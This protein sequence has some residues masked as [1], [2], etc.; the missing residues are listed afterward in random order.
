MTLTDLEK[1]V[2]KGTI[3]FW[4][5]ANREEKFDNAVLFNATELSVE[6]GLPTN[7]VK[8]VMGSL[9]K[10]GLFHDMEGGGSRGIIESGVTDEGVDVVCDLLGID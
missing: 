9:H 6:T 5:Y 2:L 1:I 10:K 4:N 7:V 8:G 3:A